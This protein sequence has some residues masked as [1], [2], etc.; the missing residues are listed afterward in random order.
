MPGRRNQGP[1]SIATYDHEMTI[2][3]Q[4]TRVASYGSPNQPSMK[5]YYDGPQDGTTGSNMDQFSSGGYNKK[6][7]Y[8][9]DQGMKLR[10]KGSNSAR[11]DVDM[12]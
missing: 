4:A 11:R 6:F 3:P 1:P 8:S 5:E 10:N 9:E 12:Q 2:D 7:G